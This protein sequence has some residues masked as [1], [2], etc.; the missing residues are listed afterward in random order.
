MSEIQALITEAID[1]A[2][3]IGQPSLIATVQQLECTGTERVSNDVVPLAARAR[4]VSLSAS[5]EVPLDL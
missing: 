3:R 5:F 4:E 2:K 1:L